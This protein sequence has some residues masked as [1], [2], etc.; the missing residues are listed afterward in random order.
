LHLYD[1]S[2]RENKAKKASSKLL[3][4]RNIA[5]ASRENSVLGASDTPIGTKLG[6]KS[7]R[8]AKTNKSLPPLHS[9]S[10]DDGEIDATS[11]PPLNRE[12]SH[13]RAS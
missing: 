10:H 2:D 12:L 8:R 6:E 9:S 5:E 7:P 1:I 13:F 4:S 3:D 11:L